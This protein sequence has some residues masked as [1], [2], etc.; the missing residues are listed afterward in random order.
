MKCDNCVY[1]KEYK[2]EP[3]EKSM[4]T[5]EDERKDA[6]GM[7]IFEIVVLAIW[8]ILCILTYGG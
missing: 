2:K 1:K 7:L 3:E 8:A 5:A 6:I 4:W